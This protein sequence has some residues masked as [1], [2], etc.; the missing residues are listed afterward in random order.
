MITIPGD[1]ALVILSRR[2]VDGGG[3]YANKEVQAASTVKMDKLR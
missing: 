3:I 1:S 2:G